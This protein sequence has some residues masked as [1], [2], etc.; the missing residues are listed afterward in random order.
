[1]HRGIFLN[2]KWHSAIIYRLCIRDAVQMMEPGHRVR[3]GIE[4]FNIPLDAV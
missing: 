3:Y 4:E 1:M 2:S